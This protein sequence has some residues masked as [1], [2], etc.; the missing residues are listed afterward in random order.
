MRLCSCLCLI[1]LATAGCKDDTANRSESPAAASAAASASGVASCGARAKALAAWM[2]A[3]TGEGMGPPAPFDQTSIKLVS[4]DDG[5]PWAWHG[6]ALLFDNEAVQ[7]DFEKLGAPSDATAKEKLAQQLKQRAEVALAAGISMGLD[8]YVHRDTPWETVVAVLEP[9]V[10]S[11]F[12]TV[13]LVFEGPA[14]AQ[15]PSSPLLAALVKADQVR[16]EADPLEDFASPEPAHK[17]LARCRPAISIL[18]EIGKRELTPKEKAS[19]FAKRAPGAW[20]SCRCRS[21][22]DAFKA[23]QWHWLGRTYGPPTRSIK[24]L[25]ATADDGEAEKVSAKGSEPWSKVAP[26]VVEASKSGKRLAFMVQGTP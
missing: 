16:R 14:E 24:L 20:Q 9:A 3:A 11:G 8:V 17:A 23:L 21:D 13:G 25:L 5:D 6:A 2:K 1:V 18:R 12:R 15:A 10:A 19:F 4:R 26:T 22:D 7:L